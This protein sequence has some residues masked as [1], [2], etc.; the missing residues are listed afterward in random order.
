VD[1]VV[2]GSDVVPRGTTSWSGLAKHGENV[3][4]L[5]DRDLISLLRAR[6]RFHL[7]H[8][9]L[10]VTLMMFFHAFVNLP[11][12]EGP[13][14][15]LRWAKKHLETFR[16]EIAPLENTRD[17]TITVKDRPDTCEYVFTLSCTNPETNARRP[18]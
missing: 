8:W 2:V 6:R 9:S 13:E 17:H 16:Q 1:V 11:S 10:R 15:K 12:L 3:I 7:R 18:S 14:G 5:R 4:A